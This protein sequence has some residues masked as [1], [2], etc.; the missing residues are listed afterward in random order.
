VAPKLASTVGECTLAARYGSSIATVTA[1]SGAR[2]A[3]VSPYPVN[4]TRVSPESPTDTPSARSAAASHARFC[5]VPP[6][7]RTVPDT[8]GPEHF[9][10]STVIAA[11]ATCRATFSCPALCTVDAAGCRNRASRARSVS[12]RCAASTSRDRGS[13]PDFT[14]AS[15]P[16][17]AAARFGGSSSRSL[18]ASRACTAA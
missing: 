8:S 16:C 1:A 4:A 5:P 14:A 18:P 9:P 2:S 11:A 6:V 12:T 17:C 13:W 3:V 10:R 15:S 7:S